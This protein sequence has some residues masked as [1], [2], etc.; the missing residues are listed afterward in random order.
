MHYERLIWISV[1]IIIGWL[2]K[3][4]F[5]IKWYREL[6]ETRDYQKAMRYKRYIRICK[7]FIRNN[8]NIKNELRIN[9]K[10]SI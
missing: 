7:K 1:G 8:I 5:L 10:I 9:R 3:I 6:K 2:T 4:P